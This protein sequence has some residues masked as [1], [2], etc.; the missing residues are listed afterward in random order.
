MRRGESVQYE[1]RSM[2]L[3]EI[4]DMG[5]RLL[6]NHFG[7]LLGISALVYVVS[8]L[9]G[10][11]LGLFFAGV[12][13][14]A[15]A[16]TWLAF[17]FVVGLLA[18]TVLQPLVS[19]AIT[20]ALGELY[21]GRPASLRVSLRAAAPLFL[22]LVGTHLLASLAILAGFLLL[23][24]PGIY[25]SL[26][27]LLLTQVI[28]LE[29]VTGVAALA[30]SRELMRGSLWRAVGILLVVA[31]LISILGFGAQLAFAVAP[32]FAFVGSALAQAVGFAFSSAVLVV[33]YF[34]IRAR[35]EA[36]DLEH[37]ARLVEG[38]AAPSGVRK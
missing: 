38:G 36:F 6:R 23:I 7:L 37:L 26:C 29:G 34:E 15:D 27:F 24:L 13:A 5:F 35:K 33:L 1:I 14:S 2:R 31:V 10:M 19:A 18:F 20:Y 25:L 4:L 9:L 11:M 3:A 17:F 16:L 32:D 21:L 22:P 28:V 12:V 8:G 30:R